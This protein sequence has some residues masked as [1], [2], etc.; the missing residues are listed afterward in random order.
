MQQFLKPAARAARAEIIATEFL[1]K[2]LVSVD[3][4]ETTFHVRLGRVS[5]S[6]VYWSV[7]K[8]GRLSVWMFFFMTHLLFGLATGERVRS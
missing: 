2:D 4:S 1:V 7:R 3:D 5:P 6:S 8:E